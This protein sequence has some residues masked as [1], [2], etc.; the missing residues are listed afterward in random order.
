MSCS[1]CKYGY[2][3]LLLHVVIKPK[4]TDLNTAVKST[5]FMIF[6]ILELCKL[7][8]MVEIRPDRTESTK[9]VQMESWWSLYTNVYDVQLH[10]TKN[11]HRTFFS[12]CRHV[13]GFLLITFAL[14]FLI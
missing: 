5:E 12:S 1:A 9:T 7:D 8:S 2:C 3:G 13:G 4:Q 6:F 14:L 10:P 11:M